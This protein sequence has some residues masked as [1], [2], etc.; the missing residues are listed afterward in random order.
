MK[1]VCSQ[2]PGFWYFGDQHNQGT[3]TLTGRG[4]FTDMADN[5]LQTV[6]VVWQPGGGGCF[7]FFY[8]FILRSESR[9]SAY[10]EILLQCFSQKFPY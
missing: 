3:S 1:V 4:R 6:P 8:D 10:E 7:L 5:Q 9:S 2:K